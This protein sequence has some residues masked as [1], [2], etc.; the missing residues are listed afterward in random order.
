VTSAGFGAYIDDA[1]QALRIA[2]AEHEGLPIFLMGHSLGGLVTVH[3]GIRLCTGASPSGGGAVSGGRRDPLLERI[4][5]VVL[6]APAMEV[7]P[8]VAKPHLVFIAPLLGS[9][10]PRLRMGSIPATTLTNNAMINDDYTRNTMINTR[11]FAARFAKGVLQKTAEVEE[12][13]PAFRLPVLGMQDREDRT[14][15]PGACERFIH[16]CGSPDAT[17]EW[18]SGF[19]HEL[20]IADGYD[21]LIDETILPWMRSRAPA[22][23]E[24]DATEATEADADIADA[25]DIRMGELQAAEAAAEAD[26]ATA[27]LIATASY[28][29]DVAPAAV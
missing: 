29:G 11:P 3:L 4:Q 12:L 13:L 17:F 14:T 26:G 2:A 5:G 16:K 21:K 23:T 18:I 15:V 20:L 6:S 22:W 7:D 24:A 28:A 27:G 10:M 19:K 1:E 8:E 25:A 9:C